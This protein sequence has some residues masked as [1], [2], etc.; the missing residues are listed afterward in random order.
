MESGDMKIRESFMKIVAGVQ[1]MLLVIHINAHKNT[2][3][4]CKVMP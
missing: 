4:D 3:T 1:T 2:S